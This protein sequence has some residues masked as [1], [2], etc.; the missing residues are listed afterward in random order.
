VSDRRAL[1]AAFRAVAG[2][3][4]TLVSDV[5]DTISYR[6]SL[7]IQ[8][9]QEVSARRGGARREA[10]ASLARAAAPHA[11]KV[12]VKQRQLTPSAPPWCSLTRPG[13][14]R[15]YVTFRESQS[16]ASLNC[17]RTSAPV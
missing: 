8:Q 13:L 10:L 11:R 5:R 14:Q 2:P 4:R 17:S 6:V 7:R 15:C 9:V 1:P 12:C 3:F 16:G